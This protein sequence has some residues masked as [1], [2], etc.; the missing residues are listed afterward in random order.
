MSILDFLPPAQV[1]DATNLGINA[2]ILK[3]TVDIKE[4]SRNSLALTR[5]IRNF[6]EQNFIINEQLLS[7]SRQN[8]ENNKIFSEILSELKRSNRG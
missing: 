1:S 5:E 6:N 3:L 8:L 2:S 7:L 4:L